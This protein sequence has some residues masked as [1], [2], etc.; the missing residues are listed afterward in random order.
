MT[1]SSEVV[2]IFTSTRRVDNDELYESWAT[3]MDS[4]VRSTPGYLRHVSVFDQTSRRGVTVSYFESDSAVQRWRENAEHQ[5]AQ[6]LGR[7][8]FY[9]GYR[10]DIATMT[11]SYEWTAS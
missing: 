4:L 5:I 2:C 8:Q 9:D 7:E 1:Q 3:N 10:I 6:S 11:R